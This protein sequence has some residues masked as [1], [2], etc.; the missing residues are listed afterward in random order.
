M[1]PA[2]REIQSRIDKAR[3]FKRNSCGAG[4]ITPEL[5]GDK[6]DHAAT[7]SQYVRIDQRHMVRTV[8]TP[9]ERKARQ[10]VYDFRLRLSR[11]AIV[12]ERQ[13]GI[14]GVYEYYRNERKPKWHANLVHGKVTFDCAIA[15][16]E[17][18]NKSVEQ[19]TPGYDEL[20]CDMNAV[21]SKWGC[22][23]GRHRREN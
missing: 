23:C 8:M 12:K 5:F 4:H 1:Q 20:L 11:C 14:V 15:A 17:A 21:W 22:H 13:G 2:D 3:E 10:K 19:T 7:P 6:H 9:E 16:A 18:R